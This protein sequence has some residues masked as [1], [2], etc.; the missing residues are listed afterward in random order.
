M[1]RRLTL[2]LVLC[3]AVVFGLMPGMAWAHGPKLR[4]S[5]LDGNVTLNGTTGGYHKNWSWFTV[6]LRPGTVALHVRMNACNRVLA[7]TCGIYV[8]LLQGGQVLQSQTAACLSKHPRCGA[9]AQLNYRIRT[10]GVYYLLIMGA[11]GEDISYTMRLQ[12][13]IYRLNCHRYC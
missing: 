12:A 8:D 10:A 5:E 2:S 11:G 1:F 7:P 3:V 13:T 6:G 9:S 4:G